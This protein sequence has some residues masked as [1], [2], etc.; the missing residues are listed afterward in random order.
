MAALSGLNKTKNC[1]IAVLDYGVGNLHSI[2]KALKLYASSVV[3][4][5]EPD[6]IRSCDAIVMPGDGA[7]EA[8]M[9][10]LAGGRREVITEFAKT[11]RP[12]FGICIG[13][14]VL[15]TDS[16]ESGLYDQTKQK[17]TAGSATAG[18]AEGLGLLPG[19]IRK[20]KFEDKS[21]RIPHMQW[22]RLISEDPLYRDHFMY[23]IHSYHATEVPD[24]YV[25]AWSDYEGV[26][27][28]AAVQK[29]NI[30]A[31]QFHPEKS[32]RAGLSVIQD[33]VESL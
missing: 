3:F 9:A 33:W 11:G 31:T 28:P 12:V 4:T 6:E 26:V 7:F 1:K 16:S 30:L 27:F 10:G 18:L 21:V 25:V 8:A 2:L 14:Q 15:F 5:G 13:F 23:F 32:D 29:E 20:F 22:N 24:R 17:E 19:K